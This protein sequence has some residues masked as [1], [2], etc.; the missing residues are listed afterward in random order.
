MVTEPSFRYGGTATEGPD[1]SRKPGR[2]GPRSIAEGPAADNS[3]A[4]AG[5]NDRDVCPET[6][7][8]RDVCPEAATGAAAGAD[9]A[10]AGPEAATRTAEAAGKQQEQPHQ[11]TSEALQ[12]TAQT[13]QSEN[14]DAYAEMNWKF[15]GQRLHK[16]THR[17]EDRHKSETNVVECPGSVG[18]R[19]RARVF[20]Y[21]GQYNR[22]LAVTHTSE[23]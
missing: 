20:M 18:R 11:Q 9:S 14:V 2:D 13:P 17:P 10:A 6:A 15:C 23:R 5:A 4:G 22:V 16:G 1:G 7:G 19:S 8:A 3:G 12:A 21:R